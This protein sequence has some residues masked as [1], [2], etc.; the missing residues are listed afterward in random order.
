MLA[1]ARRDGVLELWDVE[2]LTE[3]F[4]CKLASETINPTFT[5]DSQ[6]LAWGGRTTANGKEQGQIE[7][8]HIPSLRRHLSEIGLAW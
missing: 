5:A 7:F 1:A 3:I 4:R 6:T 2:R 8:L